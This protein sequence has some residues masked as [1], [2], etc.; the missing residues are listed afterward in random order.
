MSETV[1][2]MTIRE[3]G[4][5]GSNKGLHASQDSLSLPTDSC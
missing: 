1:P 2:R 4:V 3:F 5:P